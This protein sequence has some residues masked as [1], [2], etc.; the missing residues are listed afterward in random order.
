MTEK[1]FMDEFTVF[2]KN[3]VQTVKEKDTV[4]AELHDGK[5]QFVV[6]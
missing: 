4:V 1:Q 2:I 3:M 5:I 6:K